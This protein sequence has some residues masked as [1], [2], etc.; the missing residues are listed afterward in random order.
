MGHAQQQTLVAVESCL[1]CDLCFHDHCY[2][3]NTQTLLDNDDASHSPELGGASQRNAKHSTVHDS[4][5]ATAARKPGKSAAGK[6]SQATEP[7]AGEHDYVAP[8]TAPPLFKRLE[9]HKRSLSGSDSGQSDQG[10]A[11]KKR[12]RPSKA[13]AAAATAGTAAQES[14]KGAEEQVDVEQLPSQTEPAP[15]DPAKKKRGRPSKAAAA[16]AKAAAAEA[17]HGSDKEAAK[18]QGKG[19]KPAGATGV[20]VIDSLM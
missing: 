17:A 12:G 11:K 5:E 18:P 14:D 16:A 8:D 10:P 9:N 1:A 6:R 4:T 20:Q 2:L 19:S 15:Q 3:A 13:A 7:E